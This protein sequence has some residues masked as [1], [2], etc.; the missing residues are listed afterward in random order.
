[1]YVSH[2]RGRTL[3]PVVEDGMRS[4]S[5]LPVATHD[6]LVDRAIAVFERR[7]GRPLSREE[8][9]RIVANLTGFFGILNDVRLR[10]D[11]EEA[12]V[13]DPLDGEAPTG[14]RGRPRRSPRK[15]SEPTP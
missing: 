5:S 6:E 7:A 8:G 2:V 1:P 10:L 3:D 12:R 13:A 11:A 14:H 9:R 4:L 15:P